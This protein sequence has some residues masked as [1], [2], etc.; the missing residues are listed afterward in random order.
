MKKRNS[1]K[2]GTETKNIKDPADNS[3]FSVMEELYYSHLLE[4]LFDHGT[5]NKGFVKDQ[6]KRGIKKSINKNIK[7]KRS[8]K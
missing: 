7:T 5:G 1:N 4:I 2:L 6:I 8:S 3:Y